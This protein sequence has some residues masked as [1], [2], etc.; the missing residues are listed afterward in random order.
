M[1]VLRKIYTNRKEAGQAIIYAFDQPKVLSDK[2]E[3]GEYRS[4]PMIL[5]VSDSNFFQ[6]L[7]TTLMHEL[8]H[9]P[10]P[11]ST[12]Y[13]RKRNLPKNPIG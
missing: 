4:F 6:K 3:P 9:S 13:P 5:C 2:V 10:E 8:S 12:P 7:E 11:N 1:T